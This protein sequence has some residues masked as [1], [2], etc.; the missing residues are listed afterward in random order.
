MESERASVKGKKKRPGGKAFVYSNFNY[1]LLL[2]T[3][4]VCLRLESGRLQSLNDL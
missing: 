3:A 4:M 1:T 2:M